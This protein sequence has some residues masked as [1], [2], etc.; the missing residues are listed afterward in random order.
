M[1]NDKL[2]KGLQKQLEVYVLAKDMPPGLSYCW[3]AL[4]AAAVDFEEYE[5]AK[6]SFRLDRLVQKYSDSKKSST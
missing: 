1:E 4:S 6:R 5:E 3:T 2:L